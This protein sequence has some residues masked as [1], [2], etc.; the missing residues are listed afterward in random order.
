MNEKHH[1]HLNQAVDTAQPEP[2]CSLPI[3]TKSFEPSE[4]NIPSLQN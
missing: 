3:S 1:S 4:F 2:A